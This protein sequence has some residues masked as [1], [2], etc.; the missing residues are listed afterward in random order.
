MDIFIFIHLTYRLQNL[1]TFFKRY[2]V[3]YSFLTA[4]FICLLTLS[5]SLLFADPKWSNESE[6]GLTSTQPAGSSS[7]DTDLYFGKH[8]TIVSI[9]K[10][11]FTVQG[12]YFYGKQGEEL[13]SRNWMGSIQWDRTFTEKL[14]G[15]LAEKLEGD[16]F[17]GYVLRSN[18]DI[19]GRY[20]F[21]TQEEPKD[22]DYFFAEA[23][24]R[25]TYED[26]TVDQPNVN[27]TSHVGRLYSEYSKPWTSTFS[28]KLWVEYLKTIG[29]D[30]RN[31]YN[32]ELSALSKMS[33]L[34]TM[35]ASYLVKFDD[36]L[37]D[38]DLERNTTRVMMIS[39]IANY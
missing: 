31:Q 27:S 14:K 30:N 2:D 28:T 25:L 23:G 38:K 13:T 32:A 10:N 26:Y 9:D 3:M 11:T 34:L 8:K 19:G 16:R 36:T 37:K 21:I 6:L 33:D 12:Q 18:T 1:T 15:F 4:I 5:S 22:L 24:Y 7:D 17:M 39:L 35:K 20:Y 29:N